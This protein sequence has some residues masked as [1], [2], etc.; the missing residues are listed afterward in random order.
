M[1]DTLE[2]LKLLQKENQLDFI[3]FKAHSS[4]LD[5]V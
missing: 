3:L 1:K 2:D 4:L 5:C